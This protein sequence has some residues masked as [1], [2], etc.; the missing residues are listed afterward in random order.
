MVQE[1]SVLVSS[2]KA[3]IT[4]SLTYINELC[5]IVTQDKK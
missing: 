3:T 5:K 4:H 1:L 2:L